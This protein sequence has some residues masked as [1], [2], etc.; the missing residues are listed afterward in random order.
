MYTYRRQIILL[1]TLIMFSQIA[2]GQR[3][4]KKQG[5]FSG[6]SGVTKNV[7]IG[8]AYSDFM[9]D[10][11]A[12]VKTNFQRIG[13]SPTMIW[14]LG[15]KLFFESQVEFFT[16]SGK[17]ATQVE[18]AKL[19]YIV[20]KYIT[21]GM[22]K[23][24][25]PFGTYT[26]RVEAPFIERMPNAPLGFKHID[27]RPSIGPTG[28]EMGLD[29]R[30]GFQVGDA[31][32]NYVVYLSNGA[33]L[34]DGLKEPGLAGAVDYENY[35]DN[36]TNKALGMRLGYLPLS[37]SSLELGASVQYSKSGDAKSIYEDVMSKAY[38]ADIS[39]HRI[40]RPI[41]TLV[42]LKSQFNYLMVDKTYYKD[43][44]GEIYT[45]QNNSSIFY[46]MLSVRPV[47]LHNI[48]LKRLEV[49]GRYNRMDLAHDAPWGGL[50]T[51]VDVGISYWL[52]LRT[53]LRIAYE[54]TSFPGGKSHDVYL[55]R[56]VTGF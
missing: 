52:S 50:T 18:Y 33:T 10:P 7:I 51:R 39:Y 14:M 56:F 38:G 13:F 23:I 5:S 40:I 41:K 48:V 42:N 54:N 45:F 43:E 20:N 8:Y 16:D 26:E 47:L 17:I 15:E 30:G 21:I 6:L 25:T 46:L 27:G 29:A 36:N 53:G 34:N 24:L 1:S 9:V 44:Q 55:M 19:S 3:E 31:K 32:M 37:N 4:E 28:S 35:F 49:Q 11:K 2:L 22:G 12:D